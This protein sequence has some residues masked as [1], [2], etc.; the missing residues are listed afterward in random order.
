MTSS[1][2]ING[3]LLL[4]TNIFLVLLSLIFVLVILFLKAQ[5]KNLNEQI[6][7]LKEQ[8]TDEASYPQFVQSLIDE[9]DVF[10]ELARLDFFNQQK[11]RD[12]D[13]SATLSYFFKELSYRTGL[14]MLGSYKERTPFLPD[15]HR[16]RENIAQGEIVEIIMPGWKYSKKIIRYPLVQ[17][18]K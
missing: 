2:D 1:T 16:S 14:E 4:I 5:I 9:P 11:L 6:K 17:K 8:K 10:L 12:N 13:I 18:I 7:S 15:I 3:I